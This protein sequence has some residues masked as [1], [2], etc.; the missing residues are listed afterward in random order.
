[1]LV[2][3]LEVHLCSMSR[4]YIV[5]LI[6]GTGRSLVRWSTTRACSLTCHW[7][8]ISLCFGLNLSNVLGAMTVAHLTNSV[9]RGIGL[10]METWGIDLHVRRW[11]YLLWFSSWRTLGLSS[12]HVWHLDRAISERWENWFWMRILLLPILMSRYRSQRVTVS[13][14]HTVIITKLLISVSWGV[15]LVRLFHMGMLLARIQGGVLVQI[16]MGSRLS[17]TTIFAVS[18]VW[19]RYVLSAGRGYAHDGRIIV[20]TTW[21]NSL[22]IWVS[23]LHTIICL[24]WR[25]SRPTV[26]SWSRV[27]RSILGVNRLLLATCSS[28]WGVVPPRNIRVTSPVRSHLARLYWLIVMIILGDMALSTLVSAGSSLRCRI[29][30]DK[31][32][33]TGRVATSI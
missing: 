32:I 5:M 10:L 24:L 31:I 26:A 17:N 29:F 30:V 19:R 13:D 2:W 6:T 18:I 16:S 3:W 8:L 1:M 11:G 23:R 14:N 9:V 12:N 22:T 20:Y 4:L 7:L 33:I 21:A 27:S 15:C 25:R 28:A